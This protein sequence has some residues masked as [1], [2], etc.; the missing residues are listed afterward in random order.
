MKIPVGSKPIKYL[1]KGHDK[2]RVQMSIVTQINNENNAPMSVDELQGDANQNLENETQAKR[3]KRDEPLQFTTY[4]VVSAID[5]MYYIYLIIKNVAD[6]LHHVVTC[7]L[8]LH[9]HKDILQLFDFQLIRRT[10]ILY[11]L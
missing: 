6:R 5:G 11:T 9:Y 2:T 10:N 8:N 7:Y 4:C 3:E 1:T